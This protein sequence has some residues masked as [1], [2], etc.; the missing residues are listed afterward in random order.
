MSWSDPFRRLRREWTKN[1]GKPIEEWEPG[2]DLK[3]VTLRVLAVVA[4]LVQIG[5]SVWWMIR[6]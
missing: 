3:D 5:L 6:R 1:D 4:G 2:L